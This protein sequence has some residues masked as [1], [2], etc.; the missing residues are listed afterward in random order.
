MANGMAR[1]Q[2]T[3]VRSGLRLLNDRLGI[4]KMNDHSLLAKR[5]KA[6]ATLLLA[7]VGPHGMAAWAYASLTGL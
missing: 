5:C 2:T 1:R 7:T 4:R 3:V 6:S